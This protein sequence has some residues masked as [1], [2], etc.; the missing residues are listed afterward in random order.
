MKEINETL[1]V[2]A[3]RIE[4]LSPQFKGKEIIFSDE[5]Q[6]EFLLDGENRDIEKEPVLWPLYDRNMFYIVRTSP[7]VKTPRHSHDESVFRIL[8]SGSLRI[9]GRTVDKPGT[10]FVVREGVK[11]EIESEMGYVTLAGYGQACGTQAGASR[12]HLLNEGAGMGRA[13]AQKGRA[14]ANT[15]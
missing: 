10:W 3:E 2:F 15:P 9:N 14:A 4:R 5:I 6:K 13:D 7:N 1:S 8:L 11:Y 12:I